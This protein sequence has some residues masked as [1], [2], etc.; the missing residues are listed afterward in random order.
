METKQE[1]RVHEGEL[2]INWMTGTPAPDV[3][4]EFLTCKCKMSCKLPS[5]Q[6]MVNGLPCIQACILQDCGN[7]KEED[8]GSMQEV[9][10]DSESDSDIL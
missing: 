1:S 6:C 8:V 10:S 5:C 2:Q 4:L 7:M 9:G 3:V